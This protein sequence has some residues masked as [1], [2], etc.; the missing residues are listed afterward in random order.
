MDLQSPS[1][2]TMMD[3]VHLAENINKDKLGDEQCFAGRAA[4][5]EGLF[6]STSEVGQGSLSPL[7]I[8]SG[9]QLQ[10]A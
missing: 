7:V 10:E 1:P 5:G 4:C 2:R 8:K 6:G 9:K 3:F